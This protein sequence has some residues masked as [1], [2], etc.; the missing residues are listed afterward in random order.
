MATMRSSTAGAAAF[1]RA[2]RSRAPLSFLLV[3]GFLTVMAPTRLPAQATAADTAAILL[4]AADDLAGRGQA[5]VAAALLEYIRS[6]YGGTA[7]AVEAGRRLATQPAPG[8]AR[9]GAPGAAAG[10]RSTSGRT[11]LIVFG[12]TYGIWAGLAVPA[13][14]GA[15]GP[16]AIGTGLL[17]GGPVGFLASRAY[18]R[19]TDIT[20]GEA[21]AITFGGSWGT[22]QGY[23]L[24]KLAGLV[25]HKVCSLPSVPG[26]SLPYCST[27]TS[28]RA[29]L[30]SLLLGGVAGMAAGAALGGNMDVTPGAA[31]T[32]NLAGLWGTA[33][34]LGTAALVG[35]G[36]GKGPLA[37]AVVGGDAAILGAALAYPAW[38][39]SRERARLISVAGLAGAL[40]GIGA[41]L[42]FRIEDKPAAAVAMAGGI[43]GLGLGASATRG[44]P[45]ETASGPAGAGTPG[46]ALLRLDR[47]RLEAGVPAPTPILRAGRAGGTGR[48][49][50]RAPGAP[51]LFL[52]LF[53]ARF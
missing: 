27:E 41:D 39:L 24:A 33:Y 7:A 22:W 45:P 42:I 3:V 18:A 29:V 43:V 2:L 28:G 46:G 30:R 11:E 12:T 31:T 50:Q 15:E 38:R 51:S 47:A 16:G 14:L 5:D 44:M 52:P 13:A 35:A 26:P 40:A 37:F 32:V 6:R 19:S 10:V 20:E 25:D 23:G 1:G 36:D 53:Q 9:P 8:R 34:G 4:K 17:V 21:R 48:P 49:G